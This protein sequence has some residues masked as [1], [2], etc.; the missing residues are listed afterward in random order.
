V[1]VIDATTTKKKK[2]KKRKRESI[3]K[4]CVVVAH[5]HSRRV[6]GYLVAHPSSSLTE[7]KRIDFCVD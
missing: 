6:R 2:K 4:M 5:L 7:V 1:L 3:K